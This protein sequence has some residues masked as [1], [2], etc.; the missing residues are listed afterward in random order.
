MTTFISMSEPSICIPRVS[1][2][3]NK[4]QIKDV[5]EEL[6]GEGC[7]ERIDM[8]QKVTKRNDRSLLVFVH[9]K[10]W[11]NS[12]RSQEVRQ[13]LLDGNQIKIVYDDPWFWKCSASRVPK[14]EGGKPEGGKEGIIKRGNINTH[15]EEAGEWNEEVATQQGWMIF[16]PPQDF[17]EDEHEHEHDTTVQDMNWQKVR[18]H[19]RPKKVKNNRDSHSMYRNCHR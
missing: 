9:F 3:V 16:N 18:K 5:F 10:I 12:Q 15:K 11:N 4:L 19:K 6:F 8:V 13:R 17:G 1:I 2:N 14:P 7:I